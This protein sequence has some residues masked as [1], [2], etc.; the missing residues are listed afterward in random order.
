MPC[1]ED[2]N[3]HPQSAFK[4][5]AT[6]QDLMASEVDAIYWLDEP[7]TTNIGFLQDVGSGAYIYKL[8]N[9]VFYPDRALQAPFGQE[10]PKEFSIAAGDLRFRH[11]GAG[12]LLTGSRALFSESF[13]RNKLIH[14]T[15]SGD[16]L[17]TSLAAGLPE[18]ETEVDKTSFFCE[19]FTSHFGHALIDMLGRFWPTALSCADDFTKMQ[20]V[21]AGWIGFRNGHVNNGPKFFQ[22]IVSACGSSQTDLLCVSK[23]TRFSE[24]YVPSRI[25]P[26]FNQSGPKYNDLM[27]MIAQR[28]M[29]NSQENQSEK[30]F[31]SRSRLPIGKRSLDGETER[32]VEG[33]FAQNGFEIVHPQELSLRE[34][35]GKVRHAKRLAG[36]VGSQMHLAVFSNAVSPKMFRIRPKFHPVFWD[37]PIL[38]SLGGSL[39]DFVAED[40]GVPNENDRP[41]QPK[42]RSWNISPNDLIRLGDEIKRWIAQ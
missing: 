33:I 41:N 35:I 22:E 12:L 20:F 16:G 36:L 9:A 10:I 11:D 19:F 3:M 38:N 18:I 31:L 39:H 29:G 2:F 25:A 4:V 6:M 21:G 28:I 27:Q 5:A 24:L 17:A 7:Q 15:L 40:F 14:Y 32:F 26:F 37:V 42:N 30:V 23:T 13:G 8:Q 1:F 34:Q